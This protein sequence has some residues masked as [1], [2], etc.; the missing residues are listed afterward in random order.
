MGLGSA[1]AQL[2]ML[3][4]SFWSSRKVK[5]FVPR[6]KFIQN[7][8]AE[9]K[10]LDQARYLCIARVSA[11]VSSINFFENGKILPVSESSKVQMYKDFVAGGDMSQSDYFKSL[12]L[13]ESEKGLYL[14]RKKLLLELALSKSKSLDFAIVGYYRRPNQIVVMDGQNRTAT[15]V[16]TGKK[17]LLIFIAIPKISD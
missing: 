4:A 8:W 11:S 9:D 14:V 7:H 13:S 17:R 2:F 6:P 10:V 12:A 16:A 15:L 3:F 5:I 1:T